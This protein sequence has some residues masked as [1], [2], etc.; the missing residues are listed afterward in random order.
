MYLHL[1]NKQ[2]VTCPFKQWE[3]HSYK[4]VSLFQSHLRPS[5]RDYGASDFQASNIAQSEVLALG[6]GG[7]A[8]SNEVD[9]VLDVEDEL[10]DEQEDIVCDGLLDATLIFSLALFYM[11]LEGI[12][13]R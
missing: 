7:L 1:Y 12:F 2:P 4:L 6:I 3:G 11:R 13:K 9:V 5:H 8:C 10:E